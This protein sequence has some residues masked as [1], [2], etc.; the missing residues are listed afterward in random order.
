MKPALRRCFLTFRIISSKIKTRLCVLY[1]LQSRTDTKPSEAPTAYGRLF[2]YPAFLSG[3]TCLTEI[4]LTFASSRRDIISAIAAKIFCTSGA[5]F[6]SFMLIPPIFHKSNVYTS[7]RFCT[8]NVLHN[9]LSV[10]LL[11]GSLLQMSGTPLSRSLSA[12]SK[13]SYS[14]CL[15]FP[16]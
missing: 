11:M 1:C 8:C 5:F 4:K 15:R 12:S 9:T 6:F 13:S 2:F 3:C 16:A 14:L 10:L 7:V